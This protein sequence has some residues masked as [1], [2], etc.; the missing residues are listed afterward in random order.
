MSDYKGGYS[1]NAS[2]MKKQ[3]ES[4]K[5]LSKIRKNA[6]KRSHTHKESWQ[7]VN[8]NDIVNKF[9]PGVTPYNDGGKFI[10][11]NDRYRIVADTY[12]GYLR[13]K[14][15]SLPGRSRYITLEGKSYYSLPKSSRER[16]THYYILKREEM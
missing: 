4:N 6:E 11:S 5:S 12:G 15:K 13:I 16:L 3:S 1:T 8:L 9:T 14:D 10:Y 2:K 7:K